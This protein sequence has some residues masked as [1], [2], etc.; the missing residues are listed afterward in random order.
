MNARAL[1]FMSE[2]RSAFVQAG[3]TWLDGFVDPGPVLYALAGP[4]SETLGPWETFRHACLLGL[5][6]SRSVVSLADDIL[7]EPLEGAPP[8]AAARA[9]AHAYERFSERSD[10][11]DVDQEAH[12]ALA[13]AAAPPKADASA[14]SIAAATAAFALG[15]HVQTAAGS[16]CAAVLDGP[17][18]HAAAVAVAEAA[19]LTGDRAVCERAIGVAFAGQQDD[20]GLD[21]GHRHALLRGLYT[22]RACAIGARLAA[23]A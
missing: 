20:G 17:P 16:L 23:G 19:L 7:T 12:R 1:E 2:S 5:H 18:G 4:V 3:A 10:K 14:E 22:L 13:A 21:C 8:T 9:L 11:D 6:P 15:V